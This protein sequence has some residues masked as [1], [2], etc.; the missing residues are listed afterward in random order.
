M[1]S[2]L[3]FCSGRLCVNLSKPIFSLPSL[4]GVCA[5]FGAIQDELDAVSAEAL[6]EALEQPPAQQDGT[7][8]PGGSGKQEGEQLGG[9]QPGVQVHHVQE[10][11]SKQHSAPAGGVLLRIWHDVTLDDNLFRCC[12]AGRTT[13]LECK[14]GG[15]GN[16]ATATHSA[17]CTCMELEISRSLTLRPAVQAA[18]QK[19]AED[20]AARRRRHFRRHAKALRERD[21]LAALDSLHQHFDYNTGENAAL[22]RNR[23]SWPSKKPL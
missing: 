7:R 4:Q 18:S 17:P 1:T 5:L 3:K 10:R 11:A 14:C 20:A 8:P 23:I 2:C 21:L 16:A 19:D 6:Q 15:D 9:A 12:P 13:G 22:P